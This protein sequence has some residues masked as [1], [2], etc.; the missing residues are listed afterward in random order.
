MGYTVDNC[1]GR[2][3]R[4]CRN[5]NEVGHLKDDCTAP[6]YRRVRYTLP[7]EAR[8]EKSKGKAAESQVHDDVEEP[9]SAPPTLPES[10]TSLDVKNPKGDPKEL[11]NY[12]E[13]TALGEADIAGDLENYALGDSDAAVEELIADIARRTAEQTDV[14][15]EGSVAGM[16][17]G[18]GEYGD[19]DGRMRIRTETWNL[20][21]MP[22]SSTRLKTR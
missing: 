14:E 10:W 21:R 5:C 4:P 15:V 22:L 18:V 20:T 8:T 17:A 11:A 16:T 7:H 1:T 2:E 13:S 3:T 12:L 19:G 9:E 6:V